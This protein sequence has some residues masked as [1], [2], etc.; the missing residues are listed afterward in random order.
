MNLFI[1]GKEK[2]NKALRGEPVDSS[3]QW[4]SY[5]VE[6]TLANISPENNI[7]G[8]WVATIKRRPIRTSF[9]PIQSND[10][11]KGG[12]LRNSGNG[13]SQEEITNIATDI[14]VMQL[15]NC[16]PYFSAPACRLA[17]QKNF[18]S[19]EEAAM[20]LLD[21]SNKAEILACEVTSQLGKKL[22]LIRCEVV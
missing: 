2:I 20:W 16:L 12:L 19:L 7:S 4:F 21:E 14:N 15:L 6:V 10:K 3:S 13:V 9:T 11:L 17:L 22:S 1:S 8:E 5:N 18:N